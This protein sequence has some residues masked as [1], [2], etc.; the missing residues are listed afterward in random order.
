MHNTIFTVG[1]STHEIG[2]FIE[3]LKMHDITAVCDVRSSPYSRFNPQYN[4]E[5]LKDNL[6]ENGIKYV[7]LGKELG[8]RSDDPSCY[9]DGRVQYGALA[10]TELFRRGIERV[11]MGVERGYNMVLMCAEKDPLDCHRTVLVARNLEREG[12]GIS[13]ILS[14]GSL[15][16]QNEATARLINQFNLDHDDLFLSAEDLVDEAFRKQEERIAFTEDTNK[17]Q[18]VRRAIK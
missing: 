9:R 7:F 10:R 3:L 1:H 6:L 5:S 13:H 8:A 2:K 14:D 4:R 15:E 18:N 12:F 16:T 17:S 11:R